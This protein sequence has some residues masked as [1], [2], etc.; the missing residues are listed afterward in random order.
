VQIAAKA[1]LRE[2]SKSGRAR[3]PGAMSYRDPVEFA[4]NSGIARPIDHQAARCLS[5]ERGM[6][7]HTG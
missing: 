2:T 1:L 5:D 4:H 7:R 3:M 6:N